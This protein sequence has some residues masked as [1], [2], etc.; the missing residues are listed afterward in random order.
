M[1]RVRQQQKSMNLNDMGRCKSRSSNQ[2]RDEIE[3]TDDTRE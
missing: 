2:H 3:K 1:V